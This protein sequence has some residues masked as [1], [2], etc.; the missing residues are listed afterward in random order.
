MGWS[1]Y[2][3]QASGWGSLNVPSS[4]KEWPKPQPVQSQPVFDQN[5]VEI[6][7][8]FAMLDEDDNPTDDLILTAIKVGDLAVH[9]ANADNLIVRRITHIPTMTRFD[10]AIP[11]R[12]AGTRYSNKMLIEWCTRV[13]AQHRED[14]DYL[15]KLTGKT[16]ADDA[17]SAVKTRI[18]DWCLS[19]E[20]HK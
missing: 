15:S 17:N 19:I 3:P 13:Q 20:V 16:H 10:N 18:Q 7:L 2:K 12:P 6:E 8:P 11:E 9:K 4:G 14:W 5:I 1:D